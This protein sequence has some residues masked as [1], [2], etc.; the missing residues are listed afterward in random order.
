MPGP[1]RQADG[2]GAQGNTAQHFIVAVAAWAA[3][4]VNDGN[5]G[6]P[7]GRDDANVIVTE[8]AAQNNDRQQ[9]ADGLAQ[10]TEKIVA[11]QEL[12]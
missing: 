11:I 10:S 4:L 7:H 6:S 3:G 9:H 5:T 1:G 12:F 2:D 8:E